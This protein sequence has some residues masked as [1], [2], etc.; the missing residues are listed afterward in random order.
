MNF[1][2]K[3]YYNNKP[4]I[5]TDNTQAFQ[6]DFQPQDGWLWCEI[7]KPA[8]YTNAFQHLIDPAIRGVVIK[9]NSADA[10]MKHLSG[11]Y[12]TIQAGGGVVYNDNGEILII[13]RRGKWDLPKGKLDDGETIAEC[14][15]REVSEETGAPN[16]TLGEKICDTFHLYNERNKNLLKHTVWFKM[17]STGSTILMPQALEDIKEARWVH[18]G[19]LFH[20]MGNTYEA[21]KDVLHAAGESW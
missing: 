1:T 21:I 5:L 11:L 3:V 20:Y 10:I 16:L 7:K 9:E 17:R 4:L 8:D 12:K 18:P 19:D 6:T 14:A 13:F 15:V 2:Q